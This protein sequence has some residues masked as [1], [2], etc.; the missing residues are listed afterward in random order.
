MLNLLSLQAELVHLE[1]ELRIFREDDDVS[2]LLGERGLSSS[3][4]ALRNSEGTEN[5]YQW[6][7]LLEI[8]SKLKEYSTSL[9]QDLPHLIVLTF[10]R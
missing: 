10:G 7:K 2:Q 1:A 4:F 9:V 5:A 3:F 8:R 6:N